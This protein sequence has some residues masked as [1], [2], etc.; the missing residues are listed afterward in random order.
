MKNKGQLM[1]NVLRLKSPKD[2]NKPANSTYNP[3]ASVA[4]RMDFT[5]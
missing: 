1:K 3:S 4:W 2:I 5:Y